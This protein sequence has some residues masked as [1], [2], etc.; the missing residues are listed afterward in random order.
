M[1][2]LFAGG[3]A[4]GDLSTA[5]AAPASAAAAAAASRSPWGS[6]LGALKWARSERRVLPS[7]AA[8]AVESGAVLSSTLARGA[9][10]PRGGGGLGSSG[11][12]SATRIEMAESA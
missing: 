7:P 6:S 4:A 2:L 10:E 1:P 3:A 12:A 8:L 5:L 9:V 11:K